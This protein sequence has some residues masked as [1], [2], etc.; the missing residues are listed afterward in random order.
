[1]LPSLLGTA[2]RGA[3]DLR[4]EGSSSVDSC[5]TCRAISAT[6]RASGPRWSLARLG[7]S[8]V[9]VHKVVSALEMIAEVH[10]D[11]D[12]YCNGCDRP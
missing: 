1:M 10:R 8:T 9:P 4:G 6:K 12:G 2:D 3:W 5:A 11:S 7:P